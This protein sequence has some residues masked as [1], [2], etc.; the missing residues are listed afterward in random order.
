MWY[1]MFIINI[2]IRGVAVVAQLVRV[3]TLC[4]EGWVFEFQPRQTLVVKTGSDSSTA[5]HWAT[6]VNVT[7][8]QRLQ[9]SMDALFHRRGGTLKQPLSL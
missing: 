2:T 5:E 9:I 4:A 8:L 3:F 7:S 6:S 1:I